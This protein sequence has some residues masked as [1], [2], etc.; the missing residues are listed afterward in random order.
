MA[1]RDHESSVS[2]RDSSTAQEG[3]SCRGVSAQKVPVLVLKENEGT[4]ETAAASAEV[5]TRGEPPGNKLAG[6][7]QAVCSTGDEETLRED[8][9]VFKYTQL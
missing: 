7:E 1:N 2:E 5:S 6:M 4:P 9:P 8:N 3:V